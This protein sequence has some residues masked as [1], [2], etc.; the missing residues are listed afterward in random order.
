MPFNPS[1]KFLG[2]YLDRT[3]AFTKHVDEVVKKTDKKVRILAALS[4]KEWGWKKQH[5]RKV[6]LATI[7]SL[8]DYGAAG[9]Q[10]WLSET[11]L[12]RLD[13]A[14]NKALR[15]ITGQTSS[16]PLEALRIEAGVQSYAT[17]SKR[18]IAISL[19]KASRASPD[20]PA[21]IALA[22]GPKHRLQ[23][24]SWREQAR[25]I[26]KDLPAALLEREPDL[27]YFPETWRPSVGSWQTIPLLD[28][29]NKTAQ[30][31][32]TALKVIR[33][34]LV[35]WVLYTDGSASEGTTNGGA[36]LVVT[37][38]DP[39]EPL[40]VYSE[41]IR[42]RRLT[43]SYEEEREAMLAAASWLRDNNGPR[44]KALI[45]TDSQ[46]LV[47]AL[48]N[49]SAD[50]GPIRDLLDAT[51]GETTIQWIPGHQDIPGN[52]L[53]DALANEAANMT[54]EPSKPTSR[55]TATASIKRTLKDAAPTHE[56][57]AAVYVAYS[58]AKDKKAVK[59]RKDAV[60]LARIRSGHS[61]L[62]GVY[63]TLMD[64]T[65]DPACQ[66]CGAEFH[67]VEHWLACPG[68]E[69]ARQRLFENPAVQL[70][71]LTDDPA[72]SIALARETLLTQGSS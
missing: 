32:E 59:T 37:T 68:T 43:S 34:A 19:E 63:K 21:A 51:E 50:T 62:F 70:G 29:Q 47:E 54:S 45:C 61:M 27:P 39:S 57:V 69:A 48:G 18:H 58:E 49:F 22:E 35:D 5:L 28:G 40:T 71:I 10:P 30:G 46:S 8:L 72:G 33:E 17:I 42:G 13:R 14:Q 44:S 65:K 16:T 26:Q 55:R 15:C 12:E 23:R 64:P 4:S 24:T 67:T 52:E 1:P 66:R 25:K 6:F 31:K 2:V 60:M 41:K 36:G 38:G 53:A 7:R 3:L 9:W 20:H 11:Q 56:R